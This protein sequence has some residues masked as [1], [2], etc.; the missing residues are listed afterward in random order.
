[1]KLWDGIEDNV[2]A[3]KIMDKN[4]N[5]TPADLYNELEIKY[6]TLS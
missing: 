4:S 3:F 1:M 5:I 2:V 6:S